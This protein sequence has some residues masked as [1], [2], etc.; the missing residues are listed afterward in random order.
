MLFYL[1]SIYSQLNEQFAM[2][3][4][5]SFLWIGQTIDPFKENLAL[6]IRTGV[7]AVLTLDLHVDLGLRRPPHVVGGLADVDAGALALDVAQ[8]ERE[9]LVELAT[10]GEEAA[11]QRKIRFGEIQVWFIYLYK[12]NGM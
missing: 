7:H 3:N 6:D 2:H 1:I 10:G 12:N 8:F 9:T 11:L 4:K 5:F